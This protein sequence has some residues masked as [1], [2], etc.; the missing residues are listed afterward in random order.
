MTAK[1]DDQFSEPID[2]VI[3]D[4]EPVKEK[5]KAKVVAA[6][7]ADKVQQSREKAKKKKQNAFFAYLK[8]AD[9]IALT[10]FVV[11]LLASAVVIGSYIDTKYFDTSDGG[12]AS[13][14]STVEVEYVGSY[15]GY[16]DEGG[17]IFD[18]NIE[19]VQNDS[20]MVFSGSYTTKDTFDY[21][22][23]TIGGGQVLKAFGD[24]CAGHSAGDIVRVS[25]PASDITDSSDI[26]QSYGK[27]DRKENVDPFVTI[28]MHGTMSLDAYNRLCKTSYTADTFPT[29]AT[30]SPIKD[31]G[32]IATY[33]GNMVNYSFVGVT[34]SDAAELTVG[35]PIKISEVT[36]D[37]FKMTY[38]FTEG[39]NSVLRGI[40]VDDHYLS[41]VFVE[42]LADAEKV[43]TYIDDFSDLSESKGNPEPKGETMFFW[44]KIKSV[45]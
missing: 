27:V 44:I 3:D 15:I 32:F 43:S 28:P 35:T 17:V 37:N 18:T 26:R 38:S 12:A 1:E 10:C 5:K 2:D 19:S 42:H 23:F 34:A 21:L 36:G 24:A 16:Y 11:I 31:V 6:E 39:K 7:P 4:V 29:P 9:P 33:D 22:S 25:I 30:A 8:R 20:A 41:V 13:S 40:A 45:A 14:G